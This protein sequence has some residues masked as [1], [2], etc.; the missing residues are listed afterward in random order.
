[1]T[2]GPE[3]SDPVI[4]AGKLVNK[5]ERSVA[6][7][8]EP[9][10]GTKGNAG[11]TST[12]RTP[13]RGSVSPGLDRVRTAAREGKTEKLTALLH[14]ITIELLGQSFHA[15]KR[16]A[17]PGV[18]GV[19]W[20]DYAA[21]LDRNL[22]DLHGRVH[23][24]AYRALPSRRVYI[25]K[26]DGK[27]RPLAVAALEDKIVQRAAATV[28]N[29]IYEEDFLGFSAAC[30]GQV[31][32]PNASRG[33]PARSWS[34]RR[35]RCVGG[36]DWQPEGELHLGCRYP[37]VLRHGE[38]AVARQVFGTPDRGPAHAPPDPEM[39]QGGGSGR[40]DRH[41]IGGWYWAG[42]GDLTAAGQHLPA[43]RVRSVG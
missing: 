39:A 34:A 28:L 19:T 35:T 17:A 31:G 27:Q 14:H 32:S 41:G 2:H 9:R 8:V 5:A 13:S 21:D 29:C 43:L 3:K 25:P 36:C 38:P 7:P 1:M 37:G 15:L 11:E 40:W 12:Y 42:I 23:R 18:D 4:V 24:G 10:T 6:E 33:L 26:A 20:T 16:D 22:T 30:P